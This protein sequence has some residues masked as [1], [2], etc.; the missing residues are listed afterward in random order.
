MCGNISFLRDCT[1]VIFVLDFAVDV[2]AFTLRVV[3]VFGEDVVPL[4]VRLVRFWEVVFA[5]VV[6][7]FR[8]D[9][10]FDF[11]PDLVVDVNPF[12]LFFR[13]FA[14]VDFFICHW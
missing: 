2:P 12:R 1:M 14:V 11:F 4:L 6:W 5:F 3:E 7:V 9:D 10:S 13:A 8:V